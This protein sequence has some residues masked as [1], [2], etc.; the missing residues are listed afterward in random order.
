M[1]INRTNKW[2]RIDPAEHLTLAERY[3]SD[4]AIGFENGEIRGWF[5][6]EIPKVARR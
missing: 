2:L 3:P 6:L 4:K 5:W 1:R